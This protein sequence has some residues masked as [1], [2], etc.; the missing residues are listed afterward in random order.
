VVFLLRG[1]VKLFGV[2]PRPGAP[3]TADSGRRSFSSESRLIRRLSLPGLTEVM[4]A[5]C[6]MARAMLVPGILGWHF[7]RIK[8]CTITYLA[9]LHL[10]VFASCFHTSPTM[11]QINDSAVDVRHCRL[12]TAGLAAS[13][14]VFLVTLWLTLHR[15]SENNVVATVPGPLSPSWIYGPYLSFN[16]KGKRPDIASPGNMKQLYL[17]KN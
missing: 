6:R 10:H 4:R 15:L 12:L 8:H 14:F 16:L 1:L 13:A 2:R 5:S 11:D 9:Q 3:P 17:A 7:L